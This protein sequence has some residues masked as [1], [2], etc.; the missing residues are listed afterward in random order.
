VTLL[1]AQR[2]A[3]MAA[4]CGSSPE[5]FPSARGGIALRPTLDAL[6]DG[7]FAA[8]IRLHDV[9][10]SVGSRLVEDV[11]CDAF[12]VEHVVLGHVRPKL[13]RTYMPS[14]KGKALAAAR[15]A[16]S[17]WADMLDGILTAAPASEQAQEETYGRAWTRGSASVPPAVAVAV[18]ACSVVTEDETLRV[19]L[20]GSAHVICAT[21]YWFHRR[22]DAVTARFVRL[23]GEP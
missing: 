1:A 12:V 19:A 22:R 20:Q 21:H 17:T 6:R 14:L 4:G 23:G 10:R 11:G 16:L 5:V 18:V 7:A 3:N 2:E 13:M 9:R 8:D 15:A